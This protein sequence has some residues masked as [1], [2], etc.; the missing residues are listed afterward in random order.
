MT[1]RERLSVLYGDA[2]TLVS[3]PTASG[4]YEAVLTI[5]QKRLT[6]A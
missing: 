6:D 5:P 1:L 2:A 4:G 3:H